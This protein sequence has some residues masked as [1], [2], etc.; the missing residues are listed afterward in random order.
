MTQNP[1]N[2]SVFQIVPCWSLS[3][4]LPRHE[5]DRLQ[6]VGGF[7]C[8]LARNTTDTKMDESIKIE[9]PNGPL[10]GKF[11]YKIKQDGTVDRQ[12]VLC[13]L[14][15]KEFSFHRSNSSLKYHL[16]AKHQH[17][18]DFANTSVTS[19]PRLRRSTLTRRRNHSKSN[20][21]G[22][23]S[24]SCQTKILRLSCNPSDLVI[25]CRP[26][27]YYG[28]AITVM[29]SDGKTEASILHLSGL[30]N[31]KSL[32]HGEN[33]ANLKTRYNFIYRV[34]I[35]FHYKHGYLCATSPLQ[36]HYLF[37]SI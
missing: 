26:S 25:F 31:V 17:D 13:T 32:T 22:I 23:D 3:A 35:C 28:T 1:G 33:E 21:Q 9:K 11:E 14:C 36:V 20:R 7:D 10:D 34:Q 18:V 12:K 15:W 6:L 24:H 2:S 29:A 30:I 19:A 27:R 4:E 8:W 5:C 16:N 37:F